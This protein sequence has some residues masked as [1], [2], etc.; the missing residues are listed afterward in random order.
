MTRP[1]PADLRG[2]TA[3]GR[4]AESCRGRA[5]GPERDR[6][7]DGDA[8][9]DDRAEL[10]VGPAPEAPPDGD[11]ERTEDCARKRGEGDCEQLLG[12]AHARPVHAHRGDHRRSRGRRA[13]VRRA[14]VGGCAL[15]LATGWNISNTGA[16]ATQL[17][18][19]YGVGLATVGLFTTALFT[20]HLLAQIPG[21]R[22]SDH[23]GARRA[24]LLALVVIVVFSAVSMAT[25]AVWLAILTR[26]GL[27]GSA[28][29]SRSSQAAPTCARSV[30]RLQRRASSAASG[31][32][33]GGSRSPSSRRSRASSAGAR[34]TRPPSCSGAAR[35]SPCSRRRRRQAPAVENPRPAGRRRARTP[36][37]RARRRR[38]RP[39]LQASHRPRTRRRCLR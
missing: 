12:S 4:R 20:T 14:L 11:C 30:A 36:R 39:A 24:G 2:R 35:A 19:T 13:R 1:V 21:G 27:R 23:F 29:V 28:R 17:S 37:P 34:R 26:A 25:P 8:R 9:H 22:A 33:A 7:Q 31:S 38:R 10:R 6:Q 18:H 16:I 5:T 3:T 15:G 32:R